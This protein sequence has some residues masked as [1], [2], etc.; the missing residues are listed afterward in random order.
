LHVTARKPIVAGNWKMNTTIPEGLALVDELLP[1]L[2][3]Y[4]TVERIVCPPFVSLSAIADRLRG[5]DISV[6]AQ[7][8]YPEPKGAYTGEI[9]PGMLEGLATYVILGHSERRQYFHEDDALVNRKVKAALEDALVPIVCVG[10]SLEQKE[11]GEAETVVTRQVR[12][13]LDGV[14][15]L[16]AV[17]IAYEPI[18][19]IGTG[20]AS[21]PEEANATIGLIRRTVAEV[22]GPAIGAGLQVQYGGSVTAENFGAFIAQPEIDAALVGGASLKADQFIEIVRLANAFA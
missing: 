20:R 5:T 16:S 1:R 11:R 12:A 22:G 6:G 10:E 9:A 4:S 2:Q 13:A 21:T 17:V 14:E 18:W 8:L 15:H 19:A 3:I 7:N